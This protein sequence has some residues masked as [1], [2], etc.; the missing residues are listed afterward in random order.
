MGPAAILLS[1]MMLG[2]VPYASVSLQS[3]EARPRIGKIVI[4]VHEVF[5]ED[6]AEVV[7]WAYRLANKLHIPTREEVVR[8]EL[9]FETGAPLDPE[10]IAQTERNLR[11]L[12]F[13]RDAKV[14]VL[15]EVDGVADVK[16]ETFDSWSLSPRLGFAKK[17]NRTVWS[18]GIAEKNFLGR[19]K[20][21]ELR[22]KSDLD[23][24]DTSLYYYDPRLIGTRTRLQA[25]YAN[26][27]D[28]SRGLFG[29]TRPFFALSTGWAYGL[30][31][32]GFDQLDPLYQDGERVDD[33][34]HV[35]R[36]GNLELARALSRHGSRASRL[37]IAYRSHEDEVDGDLRDFGIVQIGVS[38]EEHRFLKLTHVNRFEASEDFNLGYEASAFVGLSA[39]A[40]GGEQS[41]VWFFSL[42]GRR[43]FKLGREQFLTSEVSWN[44]RHRHQVLENNLTWVRL[45]Y[46]NKHTRRWLLTGTVQLAYGSQ[47]DPEIQIRLGADSGLRGYPVRQFVG[48]RSFRMSIEE[49][50]FIAD[51]VF[52]L[53]SFAVAAF[54]D[55]G[56]A[57]PE[58]RKM[59]LRDF[60]SD[61]GVSLLLGRN[62]IAA[63]TPGLRFDLAYALDPIDGIGR[64]QFSIG[65]AIGL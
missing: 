52:Q 18:V 24:D 22:R 39:P 61:V 54:F 4:V 50:F 62:R 12:H 10:A 65:S 16:V 26:Q 6:G 42:R 9:L 57:W 36:H 27:S 15:P 1:A 53:V 44:A 29:V 17:G 32:E 13:I 37:H 56:Y 43:G 40:L 59:M 19:G 55:T 2:A 33:L 31:F 23:R 63:T 7:D 38:A 35:R 8:R 46:V 41:R 51:D 14:E 60:K 47:L 11:G 20:W 3:E 45:D 64:W 48:N 28:G 5:Q 34:R 58:G 25:S 21:I 49:R 30:S